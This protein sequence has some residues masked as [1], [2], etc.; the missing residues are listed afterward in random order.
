MNAT[1]G[2]LT[3]KQQLIASEFSQVLVHESSNFDLSVSSDDGQG[4]V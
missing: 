4:E 1:I 3:S 2:L